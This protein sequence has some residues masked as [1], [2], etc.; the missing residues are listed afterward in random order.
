VRALWADRPFVWQLYPQDDQAH[1]AKLEA[2][3]E[4]QGAPSLWRALHRAWNGLESDL[5]DVDPLDQGFFPAES[6]RGSWTGPDLITRLRDMA[7]A[8]PPL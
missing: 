6:V 4:W 3:L 2:F 7:D 8:P 5:P 1:H